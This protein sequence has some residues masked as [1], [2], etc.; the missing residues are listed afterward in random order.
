MCMIMIQL[1]IEG[2]V[3]VL[4][5][6]LKLAGVTKFIATERRAIKACV[7]MP[8]GEESC[9]ELR[10]NAIYR[11]ADNGHLQV[12]TFIARGEWQRNILKR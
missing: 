9:N 12:K 10:S 7:K 11:T 1:R 5:H 8:L 6:R 3:K 2:A 4:G